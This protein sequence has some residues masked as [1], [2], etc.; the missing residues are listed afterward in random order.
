MLA[1]AG[2]LEGPELLPWG[3]G[4]VDSVVLGLAGSVVGG[5]LA[6]VAIRNR[7]KR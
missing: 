3:G 1:I 7:A 5:Y 2:K 6:A 4:V